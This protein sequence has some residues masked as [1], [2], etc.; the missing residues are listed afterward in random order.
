MSVTEE[1]KARLDVVAFLSQYIQVKKAGRNYTALCPFHSEKTPSFVIFP[2][3]Q[4]W[5]CFGACGVGGD[6]FNF[7]MR[8]EGVD[9]P[10]AL[11]TLADKA[12]VELEERTP[13]QLDN[14]KKL[15]RLRGLM[16]VTAQFFHE[17]F[18]NSAEA[19]FARAYARKR[20]LTE[21]TIQEFGIG[22]AP[23]DWRQALDHLRLI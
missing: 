12:G 5:R 1:I 10:T 16:D 13:Q 17:K 22:Y 3:S 6:I 9:F 15:D 2:E 11:K 14:D 21:R 8:Y 19:E 23:K 4:H 20:G 18:V 7:L